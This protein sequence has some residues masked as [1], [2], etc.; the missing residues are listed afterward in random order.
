MLLHFVSRSVYRSKNTNGEDVCLPCNCFSDGSVDNDCDSSTGQC[1]CNTGVHGDKCDACSHQFAELT[2]KGCQP[3]YGSCPAQFGTNIF[4][5]RTEFGQVVNANCSSGAVGI[6]TRG[7][8]N[9]TSGWG[10]PDL[11]GCLHKEFLVFRNMLYNN[12]NEVKESWILAKKAYDLITTKFPQVEEGDLFDRDVKTIKRGMYKIF[13]REEELSG[14]RLAHRVD[15]GF[16]KNFFSIVTWVFDA[17]KTFPSAAQNVSDCEKASDNN[18]QNICLISSLVTYGKGMLASMESTFTNPFEIQMSNVIFG[19]DTYS[20]KR[21]RY[22]R[23]EVVLD[24]ENNANTKVLSIPKYDNYMRNSNSW[25]TVKSHI[26][27]LRPDSDY[28]IQYGVYNLRKERIERRQLVA[29][30]LMW[31]TEYKMFSNVFSLLIEKDNSNTRG[32]DAISVN[33][34]YQPYYPN[35]IE[36][37]V[38]FKDIVEKPANRLHC[39]SALDH[40]FWSTID[41][42]TEY[43]EPIYDGQ[44]VEVKCTCDGGSDG[45]SRIFAVLEESVTDGHEYLNNNV[46]SIVFSVCSSISLAVLLLTAICLTCFNNARKTSITIH[47]NICLNVFI[48]HLLVLIVILANND[49]TLELPVLCKFLTMCLHYFSVCLFVWV[50][51]DSAHIYRMLSEVRDI[52]H[53][54]MTFYSAAG[55]GI[56]ALVVGLTVGVSGNGYGTAKFCWLSYTHSS[57]WGMLGPE[58][59]CAI[60]QMVML[61]INLKTVFSVKSELDELLSLKLVFFINFGILPLVSGFHVTSL[62]MINERSSASMYAFSAFAIVLS[63]YILCGFVFCDKSVMQSLAMCSSSKKNKKRHDQ[64]ASAQMTTPSRVSRSA[65]TYRQK[66]GV[67]G[68]MATGGVSNL[69]PAEVSLAST[70]SQSTYPQSSKFRGS[71]GVVGGHHP[72]NLDEPD[73]KY[74]SSHHL[75]SGSHHPHHHRSHHGGGH[76]DQHYMTNGS[77]SD[78]DMDRRSLD[79][80]SS[81]TSDDDYENNVFDPSDLKALSVNDFPQ[82]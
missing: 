54:R 30:N 70:T 37:V 20:S 63:F 43:E 55:F 35:P 14:F 44:E 69:D 59:V 16:L 41:C 36:K 82:F 65:L 12:S 25:N 52:N 68:K 50:M 32:D 31:G 2:S 48:L 1:K 19:L 18:N 24:L 13:S 77:D 74:H 38:I 46:D 10:E 8:T 34:E 57:I 61:L 40:Q 78:S 3:I 71:S 9:S 49:I 39:V 67:M 81:H 75:S 7:C 27:N 23:M 53:G 56:P 33:S 29:L 22:K 6:A 11:S 51:I 58:I 21:N 28:R 73:I 66:G 79:L 47:R 17:H 64:G 15:R 45:Q 60:A 80:A 42:E 62:V 72:S 26:L 5:P 76:H 4:W